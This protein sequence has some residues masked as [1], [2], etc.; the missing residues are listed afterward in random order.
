MTVIAV[1]N[2]KGGVG[3]TTVALGLASAAARSGRHVAVVDLDPQ[4]NA[5]SGLGVWEPRL[6]VDEA[7]VDERPGSLRS[8]LTPADWDLP[9]PVVDVAASSPQLARRE[10][11]LVTDPIGAQDRLR[12]ASAGMPHDLVF[13]D[14][15]PSL[16]LLTVNGIFAAD[17]ALVVTEPSAWSSDGVE[18]V[19]RTIDRISARRGQPVQVAGIVVNRLGRTR[20]AR[21][22]YDQLVESYGQAVMPPVHLRT[23][24]A[25]AAAQSLPVHGLGTRPGAPEA[26]GELDALL[27]ELQRRLGGALTEAGRGELHSAASYEADVITLPD[28]VHAPSAA[29]GHEVHRDEVRLSLPLD[30]GEDHG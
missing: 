29:V 15:P 8:L 30:S 17:A 1:V 9:G 21:Y 5:T 3:K 26:A 28:A 13:I 27:A 6:T 4:A 25:E 22:W 14:C 11:E 19:S 7:L 18:Q 2:Q 23:A 16:G 20:D 12:V 24:V 10:P